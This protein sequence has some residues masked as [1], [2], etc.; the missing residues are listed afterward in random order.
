LLGARPQEELIELY[1]EATI[2]A[3]PSI[4][5]ESGDRDGIPN[6]LVEA[7]RLG[8]PVVSTTV[9]G[10][11]ELVVDGE[12]GLLVPPRDAPTLAS[13]L[14]RLLDDAA[15]RAHLVAGASCHVANEF[16]LVANT[17]RLRT[18]LREAAG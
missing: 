6:V 17:T 11:P 5:A 7:M 4:V 16:D 13:A 1:R 2:F 9:S 18:L 8:L 3:L 15:L 10:I 14:A 12:T